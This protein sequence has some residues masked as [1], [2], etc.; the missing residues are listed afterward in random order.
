VLSAAGD[1]LREDYVRTN[2][3]PFQAVASLLA[4]IARRFPPDSVRAAAVTGSAGEE[5]AAALAGC[6]AVCV[7]DRAASFGAGSGPL[8]HEIAAAM[9]T[10]GQTVP[11]NN[12]IYGL[13]GRMVKPADIESVYRGLMEIADTGKV[14]QVC[15][16]LSVRE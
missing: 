15:T 8:F 14:E 4:D 5:I 3:R 2:G 13:G 12:V 11:I 1:V 9:Y 7:M 6:K 16:W 10:A